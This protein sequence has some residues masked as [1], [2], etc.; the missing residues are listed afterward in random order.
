MFLVFLNLIEI[1][2]KVSFQLFKR[3]ILD[4]EESEYKTWVH[5]AVG[6]FGREDHM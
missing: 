1:Y 6:G 2:Q 4:K 3:L 5:F